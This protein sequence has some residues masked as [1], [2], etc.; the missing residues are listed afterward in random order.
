MN[1]ATVSH[2]YTKNKKRYAYV[3]ELMDVMS[4]NVQ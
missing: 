4:E 2:L 1:L 3:K